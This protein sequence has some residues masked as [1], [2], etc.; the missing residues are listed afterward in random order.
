MAI[1]YLYRS[2]GHARVRL[3][4]R[5]PDGTSVDAGF[6]LVSAFSGIGEAVKAYGLTGG[7]NLVDSLRV[8]NKLDKASNYQAADLIDEYIVL[9]ESEKKLIVDAVTAFNWAKFAAETGNTVWT[10]WAVFLSGIVDTES[11][12][13][14]AAWIE[15]VS[16]NPPVEYAEWKAKHTVD[17]AAYEQAVA[18]AE[19]A[20]IA[21]KAA[22]EQA[23]A[24]AENSGT[25]DAPDAPTADPAS[26]PAVVTPEPAS[27]PTPDVTAPS[28]PDTTEGAT[29]AETTAPA[30]SGSETSPTA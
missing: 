20:A 28:A 24:D 6:Q 14:A 15:Y 16:T 2:P 4:N 1:S 18:D 11:E 29:P 9:T 23:A 22:A 17:V 27:T 8:I 13:Y 19:A 12:A 26:V 21:R 10:N 30:A 5:N 7:A 3:L 25:A